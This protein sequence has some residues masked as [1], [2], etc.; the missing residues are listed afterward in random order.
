[1]AMGN[2]TVVRFR[3]MPILTR[4]LLVKSPLL[5]NDTLDNAKSYVGSFNREDT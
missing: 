3:L 4:T 2:L 5:T 1:M